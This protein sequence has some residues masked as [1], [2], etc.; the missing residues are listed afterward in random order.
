M[1]L[2][3]QPNRIL[4]TDSDGSTA[5]DT[6]WRQ[7]HWVDF[8]ADSYQL[9][10]RTATSD[11]LDG[12]V[13]V[14]INAETAIANVHPAGEFVKGMVRTNYNVP[15]AFVTTLWRTVGG[16]FG[17]VVFNN[18]G[19]SAVTFRAAGG[20]LY[21]RENVVLTPIYRAGQNTTVTLPARTVEYRL[22]IGAVD[23]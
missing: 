1:T 14:D 20:L 9:P 16:S 22:Y 23:E 21:L 2:L 3:L 7:L 17:D 10:E 5:F 6:N 15:N 11:D 13:N 19:R 4:V 12:N 18:P 8:V